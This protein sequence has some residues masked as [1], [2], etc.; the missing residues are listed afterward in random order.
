MN[1]PHHYL[2]PSRQDERDYQMVLWFLIL[3][4]CKLKKRQAK[5]TLNITHFT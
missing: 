1:T 4:A 5:K 3:V 2:E